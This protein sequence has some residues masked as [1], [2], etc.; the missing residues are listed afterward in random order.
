[1]GLQV[2]GSGY[3]QASGRP[4]KSLLLGLSR[5]FLILVPM[6]I[7]LPLFWGLDGLWSA[8]P[9]ADGSAFLL[10]A[11]FLGRELRRL[12]RAADSSATAA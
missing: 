8:Q 4:L 9:V 1:M 12:G 5:Q 7:V 2:I 11:I 10:T 6:I 3:F